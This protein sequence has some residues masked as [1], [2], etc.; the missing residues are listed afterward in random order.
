MRHFTDGRMKVVSKQSFKVSA[1]SVRNVVLHGV[2]VGCPSV[3]TP[4]LVGTASS[5]S[6]D[7][8][9]LSGEG[10]PRIPH[11]TDHHKRINLSVTRTRWSWSWSKNISVFPTCYIANAHVV[12]C[13]GFV[14]LFV[15]RLP[16]I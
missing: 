4:R 3:Q 16:G 1:C 12:I 6:L 14:C 11:T 5:L 9:E 8:A 2:T 7:I 15:F 10:V 13:G